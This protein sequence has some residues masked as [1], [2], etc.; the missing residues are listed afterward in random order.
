MFI[1]F[2]SGEI[3][4]D[5]LVST[6]IF[7]AAGDLLYDPLLPDD[8]YYPLRELMDWF[9]QHLK[10]PYDYRLRTPRRARRA[11]CW[12]KP[13]AREH[14]SRAWQMAW[15]LERNDV[16]IRTIKVERTGYVL[17]EDD[18]QILAEPFADIRRLL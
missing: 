5:S 17:Y 12:F 8:E 18:A 10:G 15:I 3:D 13:T 4:E 1:R 2:V 16:F 14:L 11:I 7:L 6:G 9:N